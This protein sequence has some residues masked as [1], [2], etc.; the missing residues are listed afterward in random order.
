MRV[1][2][3]KIKNTSMILMEEAKR[4]DAEAFG[5]VYELY[6]TPVFRYIFLRIKNKEESENIT[7]EVFLK[8]F[9]V[10]DRFEERGKSPLNLFFTVARNTLIDFW[11]KKKDLLIEDLGQNFSEL[12]NLYLDAERNTEIGLL[13]EE[14]HKAL[15]MLVGEQKDVIELKF[16][17]GLKTKE[18]AELLNKREEAIRQIQ[19]RALKI[20]KEYFNNNGK[21]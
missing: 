10:I 12:N 13:N 2:K 4:G 20:L 9:K 17:A 19:C 15:G 6:F 5:R 8:V 16:F 18:I 1:F 11:Q 14:I 21:K 7:Q 3:R